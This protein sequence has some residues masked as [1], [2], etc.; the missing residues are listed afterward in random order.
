MK[1]LEKNE[2]IHSYQFT[3]ATKVGMKRADAELN[4]ELNVVL[5]DLQAQGYEIVNVQ[6]SAG[7]TAMLSASVRYLILYK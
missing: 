6:M 3:V 1:F 2:K 5:D 4:Q 7:F